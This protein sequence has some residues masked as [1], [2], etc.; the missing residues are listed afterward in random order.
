MMHLLIHEL[1]VI[2]SFPLKITETCINTI[3]TRNHTR[4][5]LLLVPCVLSFIFHPSLIFVLYE[6]EY[7]IRNSYLHFIF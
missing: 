1:A 3:K 7:I 6:I 2:Y 4:F 5:T